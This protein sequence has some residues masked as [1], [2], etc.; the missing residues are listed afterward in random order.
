MN[1]PRPINSIDFLSNLPA[2][3]SWGIEEGDTLFRNFLMSFE[4]SFDALESSIAGDALT[5][6][7]K[8]SGN[9]SGKTDADPAGYPLEVEPFD[10]GRLGYPKGAQVLISGGSH[11]TYLFEPIKADKENNDQISVTYIT[12]LEDLQPGDQLV[13]RT[14]SGLSGLTS[15]GEMP[16][17]NYRSRGNRDELVYLQYL[18]S[19][20]GLPLR[21]DKPVD[22]NR[23][24]FLEAVTLANNRST[25]PG[26]TAL[27]NAWHEGEII[28]AETIVTD[29]TAFEN[30]VD[31]VFR[32]G[33][34]RIGIDTVLGEGQLGR[35]HVHLTV[36]PDNAD[37]SDPTKLEAMTAA[38]NLILELEKPAYAGYTLYI[39]SR[40]IRPAT[41]TPYVHPYL[42]LGVEVIGQLL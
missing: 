39:H 14:G 12:F 7:Y 4:E 22:W 21:S 31:T 29:L 42:P 2:F 16:P 30:A 11:M 27:L 32:I 25:L 37:M 6:V 41:V 34:S 3:Y 33:D 13:V 20:V 9:G 5:L 26:L 10:A 15:I 1:K 28:A 19:W 36:D 40:N 8:G 24:F 38:A 17:P 18:A 35:F 23:R